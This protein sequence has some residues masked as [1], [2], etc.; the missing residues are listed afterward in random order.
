MLLIV[1]TGSAQLL[2]HAPNYHG[3][4]FK[5]TRGSWPY[6]TERTL[7]SCLLFWSDGSGDTAPDSVCERFALPF[8]LLFCTWN[9]QQSEG[10]AI[11][12]RSEARAIRARPSLFGRRP[13][14]LGRRPLLL[15]GQVAKQKIGTR[16]VE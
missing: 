8:A 5:I 2:Q 15:G 14:L 13:L 4:A 16:R 1:D 6:T 10:E 12:I 7:E 11:A 3:F 9:F